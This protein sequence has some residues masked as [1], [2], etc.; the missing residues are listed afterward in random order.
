MT[1]FIEDYNV[2]CDNSTRYYMNTCTKGL[3]LYSTDACHLCELAIRMVETAIQNTSITTSVVDIV[4][5]DNLYKIYSIR[6]PVLVRGDFELDWPFSEMDILDFIHR[7]S[8]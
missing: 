2:D 8:L 5:D 4:T 6:I 7:S 1:E 3:T